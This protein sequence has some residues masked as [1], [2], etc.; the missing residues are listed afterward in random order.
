MA[1]KDVQRRSF[2]V[3]SPN[4]G[5]NSAYWRQASVACE[6]AFMGYK[7]DD[8]NTSRLATSSPMSYV[9]RISCSSPDAIGASRK[10]W[11]SE[12]WLAGSR[13]VSSHSTS[14]ALSASCRHS[15]PGAQHRRNCPL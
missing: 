6:A 1:E 9:P 8:Q 15:S 7:P 11:G 10:L 2:W 5:N 13:R 14:L 4:V 3:V 12:L